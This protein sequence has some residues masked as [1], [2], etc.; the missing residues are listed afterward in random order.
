M[1]MLV[2]LHGQP[3]WVAALT[4]FSVDGMIVAASTTLLAD[5][6]AGKSGGVLPW[7][8][9]V[10]GSTASLAA[11]VAVA[12]PTLVERVSRPVPGHP[13]RWRRPNDRRPLDHRDRS[14][15]CPLQR[16]QAGHAAPGRARNDPRGDLVTGQPTIGP[17][18]R[19][20]SCRP[21]RQVRDLHPARPSANVRARRAGRRPPCSSRG[22]HHACSALAIRKCPR[23]DLNTETGEISLVRG[24]HAIRVTR[25]GRDTQLL[26]KDVRCLLRQLGCTR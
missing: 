6:R 20:P 15:P 3:A 5:S 4:P 1:H 10:A 2:E 26:R 22:P 9:L 12:Q 14:R 18:S 25:T 13:R 16:H 17:A 7:A 21:R 19:T 23:G 24:N 11:N 8:L